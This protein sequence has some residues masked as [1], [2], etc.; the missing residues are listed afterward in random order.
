[1]PDYR[2]DPLTGNDYESELHMYMRYHSLTKQEAERVLEA[3]THA[4][5][6]DLFYQ[7]SA[8]YLPGDHK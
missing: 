5:R 4:E 2:I 8:W 3:Q 1:M 7:M 6:D